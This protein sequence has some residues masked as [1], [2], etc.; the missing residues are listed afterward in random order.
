MDQIPLSF[1]EVIPDQTHF[2]GIQRKDINLNTG[3][4]P[5]RP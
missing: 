3:E 5:Y 2:D 1:R 4:F